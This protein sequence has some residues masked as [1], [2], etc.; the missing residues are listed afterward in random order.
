MIVIPHEVIAD[1]IDHAKAQSPEEACGL[2]VGVGEEVTKSYRLTN[3]DASPEHFSLDPREQFAVVK[4]I[5]P[6]GWEILAV[7]HSHPATPAIM[8]REDLRLA[9]A[10]GMRHVIVSLANSENPQ[11]RSFT[12]W[13]G[14]PVEQPVLTEKPR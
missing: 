3:V 7:Y 2:L 5:R 1:M 12:I 6:Q 8:S 13:Q 10:P 9:F 14:Q 11:V 4:E